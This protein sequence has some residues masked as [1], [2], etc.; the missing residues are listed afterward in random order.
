MQAERPFQIIVVGAG[1]A[2]MHAADA[3][4][5]NS[6]LGRGPDSRV[7]RDNLLYTHVKKNHGIGFFPLE[8]RNLLQI[9]YDGLVDRSFIH[10]KA[11][12]ENVKQFPDRAELDAELHVGSCN[13][14]SP[15]LIQVKD[16]TSQDTNWQTLLVSTPLIPEFGE[17]DVRITYNKRFTF[18][19]TSQ[20]DAVYVVVVF[21][22]DTP[23]TWPKRERFTNQDVNALAELVDD[24]PVTDQLLFSEI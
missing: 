19:A 10:T 5:V 16:K 8:R 4:P 24:K 9:L 20:P 15:G 21:L 22:L 18:L 2:E 13:K 14:T 1:V 6:F 3:V 11:I 23:F 12:I 17:R 7:I